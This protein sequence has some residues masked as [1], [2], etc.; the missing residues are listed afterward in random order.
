[1][2]ELK[3]CPFCGNDARLMPISENEFQVGCWKCWCASDI[4]ETIKGAMQLWNTRTPAVASEF[5]GVSGFTSSSDSL[6]R[7]DAAHGNTAGLDTS[8][9]SIA[10]ASVKHDLT[11]GDRGGGQNWQASCCGKSTVGKG[12]PYATADEAKLAAQQLCGNHRTQPA[13][14][15]AQVMLAAKAMIEIALPE[16]FEKYGP[17]NLSY[18]WCGN[19]V[20]GCDFTEMARKALEAA[21]GVKDA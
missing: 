9:S 21:W 12:G 15:D 16:H 10:V 18:D 5:S 3:T 19:D 17:D 14:T 8:L 7:G 1:M 2:T 11:W 13:I 4:C 20:W 6:K